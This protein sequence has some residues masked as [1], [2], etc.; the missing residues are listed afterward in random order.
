MNFLLD[1]FLHLPLLIIFLFESLVKCFI[2]KK[3]KSVTGEIVL[4]TGAGHGIGRLT[5]IEFAK[6]KSRLVLWDINKH[7]IEDTAAECKRLG[8]KVH[9][10]VVD[11]SNREDIY[12]TAKK[13]KTEVG[14]VSI[15]VNNAGVVYTADFFSTQD[16]QI[17]KTFEV[18]VLAHFWT[19]K[20][21]LP[22]MMKNNHGHIVTVASAAG[23][24]AVPFL[25]AYCSSKFAAVG[26]HRALTEELAALGRTG[27][28]TTCLCPNFIN[29]G[30]IKN[31][32]TNL[33]PTL[34]PEHVVEELMN[35]I[36]TERKMIFVPSIIHL[37]ILMEKMLP[38]RFLAVLKRKINIKF[39]AVIE[40]KTKE[41]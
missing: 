39:D 26:F 19:S 37:L 2:P 7:G 28:K 27:V 29:T 9:T 34:E 5:A 11:C 18:N 25:L 1:C 38:E 6:L 30:F 40:Y 32:S 33:G 23:H 35:G 12:S 13:V 24:T 21:F 20:A 17:E 8:A 15:L 16:P 36:L 22:A 3:K 4:I 10:F 14:D 31:P 41:Q